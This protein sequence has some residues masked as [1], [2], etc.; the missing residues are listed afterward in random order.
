M[1]KIAPVIAVLTFLLLGFS[2]TD[3]RSSFTGATTVEQ[4]QPT[5][6]ETPAPSA[7]I[8]PCWDCDGSTTTW[9]D[10][11]PQVCSAA[12]LA[13]HPQMLDECFPDQWEWTCD[14]DGT[15]EFRAPETNVDNGLDV[16]TTPPSSSPTPE[17]TLVAETPT[18]EPSPTEVPT[19]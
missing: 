9:E 10:V 8:D 2:T 6:T 19:P 17:P 16:P 5:V 7:A 18:P 13:A 11:K 15:C 12:G 14:P 4:P 3:A 1:K